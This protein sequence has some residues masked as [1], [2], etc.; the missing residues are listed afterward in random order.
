LFYSLL[1]VAC[2]AVSQHSVGQVKPAEDSTITT[3][4][5][6]S[7]TKLVPADTVHSHNPAVSSVF[8]DKIPPTDKSK[9]FQPNPKKAG[10]YSAIVPGLGQAYNRQYWKVPVIYAGI[11]VAG[12]FIINNYNKYQSYRQAYISRINNPVHTDK[13]VGIYDDAQLQQLQNDYNKY[14]DLTVLFTGIGY[15]LQVI[16]AI[17]SAH[18]KNFDISRDISMHM[19]PILV[20]RGAGMAF[21]MN[22]K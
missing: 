18:L 3:R 16:D 17:T 8:K 19:T 20:P 13:Y 12:Y 11:G 6:V 15:A 10:L 22:F 7:G 21:V 4:D 14:L 5:S 9:Y 2:I 1:F